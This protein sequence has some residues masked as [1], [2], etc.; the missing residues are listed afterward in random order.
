[1]IAIGEKYGEHETSSPINPICGY[2]TVTYFEGGCYPGWTPPDFK[3][4]AQCNS[5]YYYN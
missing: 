1:M 2:P 3:K 4:M 5:N